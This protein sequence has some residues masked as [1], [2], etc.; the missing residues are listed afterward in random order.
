MSAGATAPEEKG[1]D[2][3]EGKE[4]T[5]KSDESAKGEG[6]E[7]LS[8]DAPKDEN[9][10]NEEKSP[11]TTVPMSDEISE[12]S[13]ENENENEDEDVENEDAKNENEDEE[14][15]VEDEED[16]DVENENE[17]EDDEEEDV[18]NEEG[19]NM[20]SE[21]GSS[22]DK[23]ESQEDKAAEGDEDCENTEEQN[24]DLIGT[25][26]KEEPAPRE[27]SDKDDTETKPNLSANE[28]E[29]DANHQKKDPLAEDAQTEKTK[30]ALTSLPQDKSASDEGEPL[31]TP[32]LQS[33]GKTEEDAEM[34]DVAAK[35]QSEGDPIAEK[36]GVP[37]QH[38]SPEAK[39]DLTKK[40]K[41]NLEEK[42]DKANNNGKTKIVPAVPQGK[43]KRGN[44][45]PI[46]TPPAKAKSPRQRTSSRTKKERKSRIMHELLSVKH[47]KSANVSDDDDI[48]QL[49]ASDFNNNFDP[50]VHGRLSQGRSRRMIKAVVRFNAAPH[51]YALEQRKQ[52]AAGKT[53]SGFVCP[54][55]AYLC[56]YN[57]RRCPQC[58]LPCRYVAGTGVVV[59]RDRD[60]VAKQKVT[61]LS[62]ENIF[63]HSSDSEEEDEDED[64]I[65]KSKPLRVSPKRRKNDNKK[66]SNNNATP[67]KKR[68]SDVIDLG[69]IIATKQ[70]PGTLRKKRTLVG[71]KLFENSY[72]H[73]YPSPGF[74]SPKKSLPS[75]EGKGSRVFSIEAAE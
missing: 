35:G 24:S 28:T 6:A 40:T 49:F 53:G 37:T 59:C 63:Q 47:D 57:S 7:T 65:P 74:P 30:H 11:T 45:H 46:T 16:E 20:E 68:K 32:S 67:R 2:E 72:N 29:K 64:K 5:E 25:Q 58:G 8:S 55:C 39:K 48:V 22:E 34:K 19:Q 23:I 27:V 66:N 41:T 9:N 44:S 51:S 14:E 4:R 17:D 33:C 36:N 31:R 12:P 60:D 43:S 52:K 3:A 42:T 73:L 21:M 38:Q 71:A 15:D 75:G 56:P 70:Q 18:E 26:Q 13:A 50:A 1:V 54:Q 10:Q 69:D 61:D 62:E